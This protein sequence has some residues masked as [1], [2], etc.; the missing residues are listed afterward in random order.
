MH[1]VS[2]DDY[3]AHTGISQLNRF[4][5]AEIGPQRFGMVVCRLVGTVPDVLGVGLAHPWAQIQL[6]IEDTL[7]DP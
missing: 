3:F 5:I 4:R 2:R 6:E 7:P 1:R